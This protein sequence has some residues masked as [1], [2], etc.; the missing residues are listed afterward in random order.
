MGLLMA[1]FYLFIPGLALYMLY[2]HGTG[3]KAAHNFRSYSENEIVFFFAD[4]D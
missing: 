1:Q 3:K 4:D 2:Q